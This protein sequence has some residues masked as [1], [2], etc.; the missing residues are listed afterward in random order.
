MTEEVEDQQ[1]IMMIGFALDVMHQNCTHK[2][3]FRVHMKKSAVM[4]DYTIGMTGGDGE[5][6]QVGFSLKSYEPLTIP[7][8]TL[9]TIALLLD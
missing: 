9:A 2:P 5:R 8:D 4:V 3:E 7:Q 6:Y 1:A